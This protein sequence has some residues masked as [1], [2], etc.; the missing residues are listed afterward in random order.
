MSQ[1]E[2][3]GY[4]GKAL[5]TIQSAKCTIGDIVRVIQKEKQ[6]EGI[7]IPRSESADDTHIVIKMKSGYN[8]GILLTED[9][10]I[11]KTGTGIKPTF[12]SPEI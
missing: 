3:L 5:K 8:V 2:N 1:T 9:T 11:E 10:K 7:L 4:T 12:V 6:Y